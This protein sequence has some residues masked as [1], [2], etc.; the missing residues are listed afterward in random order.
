[1]IV[2]EWRTIDN[3][4]NEYDLLKIRTA[5]KWNI[6]GSM[7]DWKQCVSFAH[8]DRSIFNRVNEQQ[9]NSYSIETQLNMIEI[10]LNAFHSYF[11]RSSN[12]S[13]LRT[14]LDH[15]SVRVN[16][17][18]MI[19]IKR[20]QYTYDSIVNFKRN[21]N[22]S[23]RITITTTTTTTVNSSCFFLLFFIVRLLSFL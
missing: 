12:E 20:N 6:V 18:S 22:T 7:I 11:S 21:F 9:D 4:E 14:Y 1:M 5:I 13:V 19:S 3:I 15:T 17:H 16:F 23:H 8:Q 10:T 2:L